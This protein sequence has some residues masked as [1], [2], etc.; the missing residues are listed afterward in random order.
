MNAPG[1]VGPLIAVV[2]AGQSDPAIENLAEAVGKGLA[3]AGA[4]VLCG[5][6]G[7]VMAAACRGA[8]AAGGLTVGILPGEEA[9]DANPWVRLAIPTGLGELRNA[10]VV[11]AARAVVAIDGEYGTLSEIALAL[12]MGR[13]VIGLR[14][15]GLQRPDGTS[16][17]GIHFAEG[18]AEAVNLALAL[19]KR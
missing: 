4:V 2:G 19:A 11:R 6:Q 17:A 16:D 10:L 8:L 5:G 15:W 1:P 12:K 18:A 13:P 7:G 9:A 3:Q 14:T